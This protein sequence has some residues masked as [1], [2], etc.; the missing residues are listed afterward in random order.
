M[1]AV[2]SEIYYAYGNE[3]ALNNSPQYLYR[4]GRPL[5]PDLRVA[6][7]KRFLTR[8]KS[9]TVH[10]RQARLHFPRRRIKVAAPRVRIDADLVDMQDLAPWNSAY[11]YF[12]MAID[13]FTKF[14]WARPMKDKTATATAAAFS[15]L[16]DREGLSCLVLYTDQGTEFLGQPF[17][18]ILKARNITHRLCAGEQFHCPFVERANRTIKDKL[19]Q[20][21][22]AEVTRRWLDLLPRTLATYNS[23][24]HSSTGMRPVNVTDANSLDIYQRQHGGKK[25]KKWPG[26]KFARGDYVRIVKLRDSMD[27]GYLPR[28]TWEIFRVADPVPG[29]D[30]PPAYFLEDLNGE[31]IQS[32]IFYEPELSKV[33]RELAE[34]GKADWPIREILSRRKGGSEVLV[35]WQGLPRSQ[36][37]WISAKRLGGKEYKRK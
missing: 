11:K 1:D 7:V 21:M 16:M 10:R 17:Q 6:E 14:A 29:R 28:F 36:A 12:L 23:T 8:Q 31:Q 9:Y 30:G 3:G 15:H 37:E 13:A 35:W 26:P 2:L 20:A 4:L 25:R 19:Y 34:S 24:V 22:T 27:R 33:D 32:G 5:L 18:Q